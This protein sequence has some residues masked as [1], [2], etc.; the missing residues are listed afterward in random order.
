M[1]LI[2]ALSRVL[3]VILLL[4]LG[5]ILNRLD[6]VR[7]ETVADL[8]KLVVKVTLPALL[9]LA[10]AGVALEARH[11]VIVVLMFSACVLALALGRVLQPAF[12][13]KSHY[14]PM[15]MTGF[16]AGML[17]YAIFGSVYGAENIFRFGVIDLGQVVFVFFIL[18]PFLERVTAGGRSFAQTVRGFFET[19]VI[20]AI[21]LGILANQLDLLPRLSTWPV[22]ASLAQALG[23]VAGLTTPLVAVVIGYEMRL[24]KGQLLK[25][26]AAIGLRLL[27]WIPF[28]LLLSSLVI[29]RLF[30][31]DR[32]FQAAVMTM[33][34]L[35]PPF[36][37]PLFM[38]GADD[39]DRTFVVNALSIATVLTMLAFA[40][41]T[42]TY[43]A[44]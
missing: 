3:P 42:L 13:L 40:L 29:D 32:L 34:V 36:V 5:I 35:P 14:F 6:F 39:C 8:K 11:L 12:G 26:L 33:V 10:F 19:P 28:G 4:V 27:L 37:I 1:G 20:L 16:E 43:S 41:V 22:T 17:G 9:F 21:L 2:A 38:A 30:G 15:L 23:L 31:L 24:V 7:P 18:V 44:V 25:P